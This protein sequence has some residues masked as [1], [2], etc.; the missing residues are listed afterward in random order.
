M[1]EVTTDDVMACRAL[2]R[3]TATPFDPD[4]AVYLADLHAL[5]TPEY[6]DT[7]F[8]PAWGVPGTGVKRNCVIV[9]GM[10]GL[11]KKP[12]TPITQGRIDFRCYSS[13]PH[14]ARRMAYLISHLLIPPSY[15]WMGWIAG[16]TRVI[17]VLSVSN[18]WVDTEPDSSYQYA[19][20]SCALNYRQ[21]AT[22]IAAT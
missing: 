16:R 20:I 19:L 2:I 6:M 8:M 22:A 9:Q 21:V 4:A 5:V 11:G 10:G 17:E 3:G 12:Y 15:R 1:T 14:D 7:K 13:T 18:P